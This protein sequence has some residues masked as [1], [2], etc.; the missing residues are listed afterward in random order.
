MEFHF[1]SNKKKKKQIHIKY[2]NE[3]CFINIDR[4]MVYIY[5]LYN[6]PFEINQKKSANYNLILRINKYNEIIIYICFCA[7]IVIFFL[8]FLILL[9]KFNQLLLRDGFKMSSICK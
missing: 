4:Y 2:N 8:F 7:F 3:F 1:V 9:R 6:I 5:S